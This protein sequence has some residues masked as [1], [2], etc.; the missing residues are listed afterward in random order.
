MPSVL[1]GAATSL[2]N[3]FGLA[4]DSAGNLYAISHPVGTT[5]GVFGILEFAPGAIGNVAPIKTIA[6]NGTGIFEHTGIAVDAL[7]NIFVVGLDNLTFVP[8]VAVF[9]PTASGN[10]SP[11]TI[12]QSMAWD[13][14][15]MINLAIH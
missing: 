10:I 13:N 6:G 9:P 1:T 14:A 5:T 4:F 11:A 12:I 8:K 2:G 15:S 3:A 7:G